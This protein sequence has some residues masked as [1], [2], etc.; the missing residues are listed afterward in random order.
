MTVH[1]YREAIQPISA[2]LDFKSFSLGLANAWKTVVQFLVEESNA[3][4]QI[5]QLQGR[6]GSVFWEIYDARTGRTFHCMTENEVLEWLDTRLWR[7]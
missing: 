7:Q 5:I 4:P 1:M 2:Q 6:D 3:E